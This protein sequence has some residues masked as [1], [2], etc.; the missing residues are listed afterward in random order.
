MRLGELLEGGEERVTYLVKIC[1]ALHSCTQKIE[2]SYATLL[3]LGLCHAL[4]IEGRLGAWVE[5]FKIDTI[6]EVSTSCKAWIS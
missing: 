4:E 6:S 3:V 2:K 1:L 5:C